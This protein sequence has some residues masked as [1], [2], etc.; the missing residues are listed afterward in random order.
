VICWA[1]LVTLPPS[2]VASIMLWPANAASV[3]AGSWMGLAYVAFM[4]QWL[5]FFAWNAGMALAGIARVSQIQ[6]LQTFVTVALAAWINRE[7]ID[8]ETIVFAVAVVATVLI[9]Q[10]TRI[11]RTLT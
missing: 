1:L 11:V 6:L 3:P 10:R 9:G 8:T 5:A 7:T 4:S 2:A